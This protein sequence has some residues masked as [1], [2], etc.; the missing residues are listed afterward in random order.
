MA[1][2]TLLSAYYPDYLKTILIQVYSGNDDAFKTCAC[3]LKTPTNDEGCPILDED[4]KVGAFPFCCNLE[5]DG[6]GDNTEYPLK[7]SLKQAM[8]LY[9]QTWTWL[10]SG[11]V[12]D[13]SSCGTGTVSKFFQKKRCT[14]ISQNNILTCEPIE[15]RFLMC[16]AVFTYTVDILTKTHL[17]N[18]IELTG[19]SEDQVIADMFA[20]S[21]KMKMKKEGDVYY[22]YPRFTFTAMSAYGVCTSTTTNGAAGCDGGASGWRDNGEFSVNVK[23]LGQ[24]TAAPLKFYS[25]IF[26]DTPSCRHSGASTISKLEFI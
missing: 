9:W 12:S 11:I 10:F 25:K 23:I 2:G 15:K 21:I 17:G 4:G 1:C 14:Y 6:V 13:T 3:G 8:Q 7:L 18:G 26:A 5:A 16:P 22:F 24:S 19:V 20:P